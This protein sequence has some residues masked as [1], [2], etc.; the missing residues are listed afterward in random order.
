[1]SNSSKQVKTVSEPLSHLKKSLVNAQV[2]HNKP[3]R[4]HLESLAIDEAK[5]QLLKDLLELVSACTWR[6][7]LNDDASSRRHEN[8]IIDPLELRAAIK[9]YV[10]G[11]EDE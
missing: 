9:R 6:G 2:A 7:E 10:N 11:G 1:M 3:T 4:E 5:A 8:G